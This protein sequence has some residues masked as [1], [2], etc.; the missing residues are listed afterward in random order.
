MGTTYHKNLTGTDLHEPKGVANATA[1]QIYVAGGT[2]SGQWTADLNLEGLLLTDTVWTDVTVPLTG[3]TAPATN[4]A[5]L[6]NVDGSGIFVYG[7][8]N[9]ATANN[10]QFT[11]QLPHGYKAG[12]N[13]KPHL[14]LAPI[15]NA[16]GN[17]NIGVTYK[18]SNDGSAMEATVTD[19]QVVVLPSTTLAQD[20]LV[21]D[22]IAGTNLI[23]SSII[24]GTLTRTPGAGDD[25]YANTV[26]ALSF[27]VHYEVEKL[28]SDAE[29]P[30]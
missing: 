5:V 25:N 23:E 24:I 12:T 14:H 7:F 3:T 1:N 11:I 22:D 16:G 6:T 19:Y 21:F 26:L 27:D 29:Y 18:I 13:I 8:Q 9:G 17:A 15:D 10:L 4:P 30:S 2:G 28:G 20:V